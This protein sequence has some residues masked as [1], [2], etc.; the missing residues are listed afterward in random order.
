MV[1]HTMATVTRTMAMAIHTTMVIHTGAAVI[2][3]AATAEDTATITNQNETGIIQGSGQPLPFLCT[4]RGA[5][6]TVTY[7][8][9]KLV[10]SATSSHLTPSVTAAWA[11]TFAAAPFLKRR[12]ISSKYRAMKHLR[13]ISRPWIGLPMK[14]EPGIYLAVF[15]LIC[16]MR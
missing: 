11:V 1:T 7:L 3:E 12:Q 10:G 9:A 14:E 15:L 4:S 6:L 5:V 13:R 2:G 8:F 16:S